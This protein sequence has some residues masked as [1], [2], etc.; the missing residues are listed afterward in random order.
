MGGGHRGGGR[1][2]GND[3][4]GHHHEHHGHHGRKNNVIH[5]ETLQYMIDNNNLAATGDVINNLNFDSRSSPTELHKLELKPIID[6]YIFFYQVFE[7]KLK[8]SN[9]FSYNF[10]SKTNDQSVSMFIQQ[11]LKI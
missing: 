9:V 2:W 1:K 7:S 8:S 5:H 11:I 6:D 3:G 4:R 10:V